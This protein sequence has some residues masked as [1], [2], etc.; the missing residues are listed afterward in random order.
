MDFMIPMSS[1]Y[2]IRGADYLANYPDFQLV[3]RDADLRKLSSILIRKEANST[4]LV[5]PEGVGTTALCLGLQASKS[6]PDAPFDIVS[7][8]L[9]WLDTDG[10]FSSGDGQKIN[11]FFQKAMD[12][13]SQTPDS[14]LIIE[15]TRDFIEGSRKSGNDHF[16]NA[17]TMAVKAQKTQVI[18]EVRDGD[19]D[20]VLKWHSDLRESYTLLDLEEPVGDDLKRIVEGVSASLTKH[21]GIP[22]SADALQAAIDLTSKYRTD[23]GVLPVAQ[24]KRS[25]ALLDRALS[26]YRLE[27]HKNPPGLSALQQMLARA[28]SAEAT[29]SVQGEIDALLKEWNARQTEIKRLY[30]EQRKGEIN[31]IELKDELVETQKKEEARRAQPKE[32]GKSEQEQQAPRRIGLFTKAAAMGGFDSEEVASLKTR[33]GQFETELESNRDAFRKL[34]EEI[35]KDLQLSRPIVVAEFS[36]ISGISANKLDEDERAIL[37]NLDATLRTDVFGQDESILKVSNA[38]KVARVGRRNRSKP[39]ASFMFLGPSG[40]GKTQVAKSIAKALKGDEKAMLRLDMSEYMEKHAVAKLIGAPPGYE[41]FEAGGIL[42]NAMRKDRNRIILFDEIEKAHPDVFNILLQVLDD[43][44]LTDNIGRVVSFDEA[45]IIC[46]TNTGQPH[47]LDQSLSF[48]EA[49]R[50][51]LKDLDETYRAEFLNRFNGRQNILCFN[52]LGLDSIEKIVQREL[53][54]L[55]AA[56]TAEGV[57]SEIS[58]EAI[59]SFCADHYDPRVGARGLPGYIQSNLE[60]IIVDRILDL[61]NSHGVFKIDYNKANRIF[62]VQFEEAA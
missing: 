31:I 37:R 57:S 3:G 44:R 48:E 4:L 62:D 46:T 36:R 15:D 43:G 30:G 45:I 58:K 54:D 11:E 33:I 39:Q 32:D 22:V 10:L 27:A 5:G 41:G 8:R 17:I 19:L 61:P 52:R 26:T 14:I 35:N 55:D 1:S 56:Y 20:Q 7:K 47:F 28:E 60:P 25:L 59:K 12:E 18:L 40:V 2:L 23:D 24:P 29:Q 53:R 49:E 16:I 6:D 51:A 50:R 21:H 38:I 13:L 34:T 9:H 42:T